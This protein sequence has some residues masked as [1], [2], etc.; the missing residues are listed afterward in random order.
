[1]GAS[2]AVIM[3][4]FMLSM[5]KNKLLNVAIFLGSI[6]MFSAALWLVRSQATITDRDYMKAMIP[7]HSIAIMT[8]ER[9]QITDPRVRKLADEIIEAQRREI[10]EMKYLVDQLESVE[11]NCCH[12]GGCPDAYFY[13][14]DAFVPLDKSL[15]ADSIP[16][17]IS[18]VKSTLLEDKLE[19]AEVIQCVKFLPEEWIDQTETDESLHDLATKALESDNVVLG[20]FRSEEIQE[21]YHY[22]H[23]VQESD[24]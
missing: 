23:T 6:A 17:A 13:F 1:M 21:L 16:N 8:S 4:S 15:G 5:Y 20:T 12:T 7:H 24:E 18:K 10:A 3:L 11:W 2:M 9:A 14:V 19:L 22:K